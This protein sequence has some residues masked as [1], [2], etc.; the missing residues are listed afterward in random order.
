MN[1]I[2]LG[3]PPDSQRRK[4]QRSKPG[5]PLDHWLILTKLLALAILR[6]ICH[7]LES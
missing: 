1:Q 3:V 7:P 4:P 5:L 6:T 2:S